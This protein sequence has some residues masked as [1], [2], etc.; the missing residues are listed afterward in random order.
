MKKN[1][2][3]TNLQLLVRSFAKASITDIWY[4]GTTICTSEYHAAS[5]VIYI[6]LDTGKV[7]SFQPGDD[8]GLRVA[9]GVTVKEV[10]FWDRKHRQLADLVKVSNVKE[11]ATFLERSLHSVKVNW[12]YKFKS[13]IFQGTH[14]QN[15]DYPQSI[16]FTYKDHGTFFIEATKIWN[17][18][19]I[20][21]ASYHLTIFF[22]TET[23]EA[24]DKKSK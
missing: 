3:K 7:Y 9:Y 4:Q 15:G 14:L 17:D 5:K 12:N 8:L 22:N 21:I 10:P 6:A 20:T 24:Y 18:T 19:L 23:K 11:W 13:Q 2:V 1:Q 16:E